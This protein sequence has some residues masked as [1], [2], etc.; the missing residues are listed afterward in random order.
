MMVDYKP[1]FRPI[2]NFGQKS[3]VER[4]SDAF[5]DSFNNRNWYLRDKSWNE[6]KDESIK[7]TNNYS[8]RIKKDIVDHLPTYAAMTLGMGSSILG[9]Y[10]GAQNAT[11]QGYDHKFIEWISYGWELAF[12]TGISAATYA[13]IS[14]I[15]GVSWGKIT[16][17]LVELAIVTT[18]IQLGPYAFGRNSLADHFMNTGMRPDVAT[19]SAQMSLLVPYV[20]TAKYTAK[21]LVPRVEAYLKKKKYI[22]NNNH[23]CIDIKKDFQKNVKSDNLETVT[24]KVV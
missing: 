2:Y 3:L 24:E 7:T 8:K 6:I 13:T 9:N 1:Q 15:R 16:R 11:E 23:E 12:H 21:S 4:V 14:K 17:D 20:V 19:L 22:K 18:P 5:W 10:L